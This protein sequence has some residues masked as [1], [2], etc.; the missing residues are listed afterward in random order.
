MAHPMKIAN[1]IATWVATGLGIG[2]APKAPGSVA[3]L[4]AMLLFFPF[5]HLSPLLWAALWPILFVVGVNASKRCQ[6]IWKRDDPPQIVIDEI[7]AM[8]LILFFLPVSWI[9]WTAGFGLFRFFDILKPPPIKYCETFPHGWGIMIDD[10]AAALYTLTLL[11]GLQ[12]VL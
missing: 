12:A 2:Y 3:S 10:L 7:C 6:E 11:K 8:L 9:G 4:F 5:R 1:L